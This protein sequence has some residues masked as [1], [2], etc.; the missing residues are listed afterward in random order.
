MRQPALVLVGED[1]NPRTG[2]FQ[3]SFE[4]GRLEGPSKQGVQFPTHVFQEALN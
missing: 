3:K 4:L 2:K 1:S